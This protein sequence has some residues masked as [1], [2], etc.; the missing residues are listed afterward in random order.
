MTAD[1]IDASSLDL[2]TLALV[3]IAALVAV[4]APAVSYLLNIGAARGD[5]HRPRAGPRCARGGRA[6]RRHGASRV[7]DDQDRRS[8]RGIEVAELDEQNED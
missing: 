6:D 8:A 7:R 1:S 5:R 3:R 4:D 2:A